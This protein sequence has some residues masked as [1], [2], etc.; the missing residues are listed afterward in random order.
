MM[1]VKSGENSPETGPT[2]FPGILESWN[3]GI[4][5][6][7]N[8]P[9]TAYSGEGPSAIAHLVAWWPGYDIDFKFTS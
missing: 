3:P 6:S 4:L 9:E 7:W 8:P 1:H 2:P 5:E